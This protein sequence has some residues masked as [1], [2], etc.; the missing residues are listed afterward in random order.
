MLPDKKCR[1]RLPSPEP[2]EVKVNFQF[3]VKLN[4]GINNDVLNLQTG[5]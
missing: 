4:L 2:T 1:E 3:N 5:S